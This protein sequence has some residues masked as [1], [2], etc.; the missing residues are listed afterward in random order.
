MANVNWRCPD[1]WNEW[2]EWLAAGMHARN[3]WRLPVLMLGIL[4]ARGRRTVTTWLRA[5]GIRH[6]Y[7]DYYYFLAALGRKT[8][9]VATRLFLL[10]L[11][12]L[13]LPER[14][15][16]VIDDSPTKRYGPKVEG[17]D[18]HHNPTPGP[19]DQKY[20][21][22][23]HLGPSLPGLATSVVPGRGGDAVASHAV[24][25]PQ[26]HADDPQEAKLA[27]SYQARIGRGA[28][29]MAGETGEKGGENPLGGGRWRL[30]QVAILEPGIGC[31]RG[32]RGPTPQ[33]RRLARSAAHLAVGP[34]AAAAADRAST[35]RTR[36]AWPSVP[37]RN[38]AGKRWP[39][40]STTN[41][42]PSVARHSSR[43]IV[44]RAG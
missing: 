37:G 31:G 7:A 10:L 30:Y 33:G 22:W 13:P 20:L 40:L 9:S 1:E 36:S 19:A 16:A 4:F 28:S 32:H 6:D 11:R 35:A 3:R 23:T 42:P 18:I 29:G 38:A 39:V 15:L 43:P 26:D 27:V 34:A 24:C 12:K 5:I 2:N 25:P 41:R 14:L 44:P 21:V 8:E 17:A